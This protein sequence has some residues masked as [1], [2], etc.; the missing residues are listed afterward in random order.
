MA[1]R[2]VIAVRDPQIPDG[3]KRPVG[4]EHR[5]PGT[6]APVVFGG[7]ILVNALSL[8]PAALL[9]VSHDPAQVERL[10]DRTVRIDLPNTCEPSPA[11]V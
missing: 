1:D 6:A 11:A 8:E 2:T 4:P 7:S 3:T 9:L 5:R 10:C